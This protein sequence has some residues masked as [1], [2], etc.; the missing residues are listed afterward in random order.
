M[1]L[2]DGAILVDPHDAKNFGPGLTWWPKRPIFGAKIATIGQNEVPK[3]V[4]FCDFFG[5]IG[6]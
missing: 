2:G 1:L 5:T 6:L 4:P 3:N